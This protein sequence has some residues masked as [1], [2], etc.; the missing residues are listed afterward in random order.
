MTKANRKTG[1]DPIF[2]SY[3]Q[4]KWGPSLFSIGF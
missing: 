1:T 2:R 4:G 3:A